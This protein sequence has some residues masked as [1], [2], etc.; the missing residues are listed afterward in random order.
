MS[1]YG[2][3]EKDNVRDE[4]IRFLK[5]NKVSELLEIV[6]EAV[7]EKEEGYLDQ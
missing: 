1:Y 7:S 5:T 3:S 4:I 6:A 2:N